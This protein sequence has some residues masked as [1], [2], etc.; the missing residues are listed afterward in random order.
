M[1]QFICDSQVQ[2]ILVADDKPENLRLLSH[3]LHEYGFRVRPVRDGYTAL[4]SAYSEPP[5]LI[6]LDIMMPA[7]DGYEVCRRLKADGRTQDIPVIFVSALDEVFDKIKAFSVGGTDYI[8]KP[9]QTAEVVLRVKTQLVT[10]NLQRRLKLQN[11]RLQQEIAERERAEK[12]L[13]KA[14]EAAEAANYAKSAFLANISHELRTPLTAILG[15]A[16][17]MGRNS[18]F[19]QEDQENL[20]VI[21][22][23]GEHLLSLINQV[24]DLSKIESGKMT[25]NPQGF[26][27]YHVLDDIENT[28]IYKAKQKKLGLHFEYAPDVP[29]FIRADELKLRQIL[30]NLLNNAIKFTDT[31][32]VSLQVRLVERRNENVNA[33]QSPRI[34][35]QFSVEDTGPGIA[36]EERDKLFEAFH[37]TTTG[38]FVQGGTGLGLALSQKLVRLMGGELCLESW[39]GQNTTFTFDMPCTALDGMSK[40][41]VQTTNR[42]VSL[43][44]DCTNYRLLVADDNADNRQVF[45]KLLAPFGF[46][47]REAATGRETVDIWTQWQPH[48]IWMDARMPGMSGYEAAQHIREFEG[49]PP[50][51]LA[52]YIIALSASSLEAERT[53]ALKKGCN[54][55]LRKPFLESDIFGLLSKYLNISPVYEKES[56]KQSNPPSQDTIPSLNSV[57]L[58]TVT[59]KCRHDFETAIDRLDVE[60]A[61]EV[62]HR[63][64]GQYPDAAETL[65]ELVRMYRFDVLHDFVLRWST[66]EVA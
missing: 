28:F 23:N 13:Q 31:G 47:I 27:L 54:D 37:Q 39:V 34:N 20:S 65:A 55:F 41:Q 63:I 33:Q 15:F 10:R 16:Q 19:S 3:I 61:M 60:M 14:K 7:L 38:K 49:H 53:E 4:R 48:L 35:L 58:I 22:R 50:Y 52:P 46:Q 11:S 17:I 8:T 21:Q 56:P 66:K 45:V 2:S 57:A 62:I 1:N 29:Q 5:D 25:V 30:L 6:L 36:E 44:S 64:Q 40:R 9:F 26:D 32:G 18:D 12:N 42:I 59:E 43:Q 24:L 51:L